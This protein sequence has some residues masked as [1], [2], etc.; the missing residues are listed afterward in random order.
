M[1]ERLQKKDDTGMGESIGDETV[2]AE[3]ERV[4][5]KKGTEGVGGIEVEWV[6]L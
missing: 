1:D 4:E 2:A 3:V 6:V 5:G